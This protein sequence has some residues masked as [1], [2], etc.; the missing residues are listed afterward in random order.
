MHSMLEVGKLDIMAHGMCIHMGS[1]GAP[2]RE[3][4]RAY[5]GE[6]QR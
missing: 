4:T 3:K 6:L 1:I 5:S 2:N